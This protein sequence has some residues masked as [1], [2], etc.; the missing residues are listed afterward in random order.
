MVL[1]YEPGTAPGRGGR[2]TTPTLD[3]PYKKMMEEK[4]ATSPSC[5][6]LIAPRPSSSGGSEDGPSARGRRLNQVAGKK[7]SASRTGFGMAHTAGAHKI[8]PEESGSASRT[9]SNTS[10]GKK[11]ERR[12][13]NVSILGLILEREDSD[14]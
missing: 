12:S 4:V 3:G 11:V 6:A 1:G 14:A 10:E 7:V 8:T 9:S 5:S 13:A 2:R